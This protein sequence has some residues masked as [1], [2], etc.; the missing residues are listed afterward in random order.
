MFSYAV[1]LADSPHTPKGSCYE[2]DIVSLPALDV[3][4]DQT[5]ITN[6]LTSKKSA[7]RDEEFSKFSLFVNREKTCGAWIECRS[8]FDLHH[9]G[10]GVVGVRRVAVGSSRR[11]W[12]GIADIGSCNE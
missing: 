10:M 4:P 7:V 6:L 2:Y 9:Q 3:E 5:D 8:T 1:A 11:S 12:G